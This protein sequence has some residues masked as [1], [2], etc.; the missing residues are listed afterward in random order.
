[1]SIVVIATLQALPGRRDEV[2][3]VVSKLAPKVH[4]EQGCHL[5]APHTS[6]KDEVVLVE[7]WA[8]KEALAAHAAGP[9][10]AVFN[11][12]V[13][14][15]LTGAPRIQVLRPAPAGE[16]RQGALGSR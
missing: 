3:D 8:D 7:H 13:S 1:M 9:Q 16:T 15:L 4:A 2:L 11:T 14:D 12:A 5:Y 6:G 10:M